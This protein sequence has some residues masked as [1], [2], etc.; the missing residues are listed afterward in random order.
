MEITLNHTIVYCHNKI[1]S[2]AFYE[3]IFGFQFIK[4]WE[5]FA[6]VKVNDSFTLDFRDKDKFTAQH[7]AFK[8]SEQ[9]FDQILKRIQQQSI[10]YGP[11]PDNLSANLI[12]QDYGGRG[13]YF[14]DP[15]QHVLEIVTTDYILD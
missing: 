2:A 1:E 8:V 4:V 10:A 13:A 9:Q 7:Y 11:G 14:K 5:N 3:N 15:N 12:N 6:V